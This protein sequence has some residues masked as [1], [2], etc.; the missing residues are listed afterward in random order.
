M[1]NDLMQSIS[2]ASD[3]ISKM[4]NKQTSRFEVGDLTSAL[5][6]GK[7]IAGIAQQRRA[8]DIQGQ[9][10]FMRNLISQG[11]L[12]V[13]QGRLKIDQDKFEFE[14]AKEKAEQLGEGVKA[15]TDFA[16]RVGG[17][18]EARVMEIF[19][20]LKNHPK[21]NNATFKHDVEEIGR[22]FALKN[23]WDV[24]TELELAG[25]KKKLEREATLEAEQ[26]NLLDMADEVS[27]L[28][29][30]EYYGEIELNESTRLEALRKKLQIT[31]ETHIVKS[32]DENGF[33][34][35]EIR[36]KKDGS[37]VREIRRGP[38]KSIALTGE[39]SKTARSDEEVE[40]RANERQILETNNALRILDTPA[41]EWSMG[42]RRYFTEYI[43]HGIADILSIK[44]PRAG[45]FMGPKLDQTQAVISKMQTM[46]GR[47]VKVVTGDRSGRYSDRDME[48]AE[49]AIAATKP[50]MNV[51]SAKAAFKVLKATH[52]RGAI[53]TRMKQA[54][55][56]PLDGSQNSIA[57]WA[58]QLQ[59][60]YPHYNA[61]EAAAKAREDLSGYK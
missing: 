35:T 8:L 2:Q 58:T 20:Y 41:A 7:P 5:I 17:K 18:D 32:I 60:Y 57:I 26:D 28:Q 43:G 16:Q 38:K 3:R 37:L 13:S 27:R 23:G 31:P 39:L 9:N 48:R 45:V 15:A 51:R 54:E 40:L 36:N 44:N 30:A 59:R 21:V 33:E 53:Y 22:N 6:S 25:T 4:L 50:L 10:N 34:V 14:T 46:L 1:A 12:Q 52:I 29:N 11:T 19:N 56:D 55:L 49:A 47:H 61:A 42:V 24:P